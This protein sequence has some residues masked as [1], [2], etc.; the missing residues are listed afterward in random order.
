VRRLEFDYLRAASRGHSV[1]VEGRFSAG[2]L[3]IIDCT[4][5]YTVVKAN[6]SDI[7]PSAIRSSLDVF[8]AIE[9]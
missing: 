4:A 1:C 5:R 2:V 6:G 3:G 9:L 8:I 7:Y